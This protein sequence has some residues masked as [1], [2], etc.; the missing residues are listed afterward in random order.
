MSKLSLKSFII[1]S[2]S[3]FLI[4]FYGSSYVFNDENSFELRLVDISD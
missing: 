2:L 4:I 1:F 3:S